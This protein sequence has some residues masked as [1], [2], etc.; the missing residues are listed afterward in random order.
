M[1]SSL[2]PELV[3]EII[4]ATVPHSFHSTTYRTRQ[5]TLR[6]ISLVSKRFRAIAQPLLLE[7][8]WLN[9]K[10]SRD[11]FCNGSGGGGRGMQERDCFVKQA[12]LSQGLPVLSSGENRNLKQLLSSVTALSL[13]HIPDATFSLSSLESLNHL[14]ILCLA[15]IDGDLPRSLTLPQL[16]SLTLHFVNQNLL[17]SLLDPFVLPNLRN[18]VFSAESVEPLQITSFNRLLPQL[19]TLFLP[20]RFW[21]DPAATFLNSA[22]E[23]ALIDLSLASLSGLT[24]ESQHLKDFIHVRILATGILS[25]RPEA[26]SGSYLRPF[27]RLLKENPPSALK[28]IYLDSTLEHT[29]VLATGLRAPLEDLIRVCQEKNFEIVFETSPAFLHLDNRISP[30]FVKRQKERRKKVARELRGTHEENV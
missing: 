24:P 14:T 9:S 12:I 3:R 25:L 5:K 1:I 4:E 15:N 22:M 13:Y 20:G 7:I 11:F 16:H 6:S 17:P 18:L 29:S 27:A 23:R 8:V 19:E 26:R 21:L 2:P 28:T 10:R 30:D